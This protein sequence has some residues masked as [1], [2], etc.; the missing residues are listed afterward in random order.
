MHTRYKGE[1]LLHRLQIQEA[2]VGR[3]AQDVKCDL[4]RTWAIRVSQEPCPRQTWRQPTS[5]RSLS[6]SFD[7]PYL[8]HFATRELRLP[9][10]LL[11]P[12]VPEVP[13]EFYGIGD[14]ARVMIVCER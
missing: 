3:I 8:A 10:I 14:M 12:S 13:E 1:I 6:K 7:G 4:K 11:L 9:V 5:A 2:R